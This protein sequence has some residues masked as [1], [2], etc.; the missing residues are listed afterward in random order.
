MASIQVILTEKIEGLGAEADV[1]KV[2]G[3]YARNF[4]LPKGIAYEATAGNL[5]RSASLKAKRQAREEAELAAAK[6]TAVALRKTVLKLE[7]STGQGGKSFGSVTA[8]DIA[9]AAKE[10]AG[11]TIDRHHIVLEK[12]IKATG[13]YSVEVKFHPELEATIAVV[14]TAK[15]DP[16]QA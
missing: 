4:L 8:Q 7:L 14:V 13:E 5:N 3:G 1:V 15:G 16:A 11:L 6:E 9:K 12:P 10:Q 2:R